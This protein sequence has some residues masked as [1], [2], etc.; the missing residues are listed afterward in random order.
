M[1]AG[2]CDHPGAQPYPW[3]AEADRVRTARVRRGVD[4]DSLALVD[5]PAGHW[6][7]A[8]VDRLAARIPARGRVRGRRR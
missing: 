4:P 7:V 8:E 3:R 2:D 5:C 1:S 6:H